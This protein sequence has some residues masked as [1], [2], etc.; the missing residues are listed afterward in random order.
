VYV[1]AGFLKDR[2]ISNLIF[3]LIPTVFWSILPTANVAGVATFAA[4]EEG[5]LIRDRRI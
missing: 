5:H 4:A 2:D 1:K 3:L